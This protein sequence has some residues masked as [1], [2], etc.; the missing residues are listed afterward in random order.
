MYDL[1]K[2]LVMMFAEA[3]SGISF[4]YSGLDAIAEE[5]KLIDA[6]LVI[7]NENFGRQIF[8]LGKKPIE[9]N[10]FEVSLLEI[11][12]GIYPQPEKDFDQNAIIKLFEMALNIDH[13]KHD[14][15][16]DGLT[17]LLNRRS[18]DEILVNLTFQSGRYGWQ[19]A[20]VLMDLNDFKQINDTKGHLEG[21]R[22]LKAV[23]KVLSNCLRS[24]DR[25][26]RVGGDEFALV[27]ANATDD[28]ASQVVERIKRSLKE[29]NVTISAGSAVAPAEA[30][31]IAAL[32]GLADTRLYEDKLS[33]TKVSRDN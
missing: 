24:G 7:E 9:Q 33:R 1:I 31:E 15:R 12:I 28:G 6:V 29:I 22:I 26:A 27:L 13:F 10:M 14:A 19:F 4:I 3:N 20:L 25:V 18:F 11:P 8:R 2:N 5:F 23:S 21:D 30:T 32:W 17:N 16:H